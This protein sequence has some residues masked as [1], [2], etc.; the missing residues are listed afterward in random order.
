MLHQTSF[1]V[2]YKRGCSGA[3]A[4][5][6]VTSA[7]FKPAFATSSTP[8]QP[9]EVF[10]AERLC[11]AH[12]SQLKARSLLAA[13][14]DP[15]ELFVV[16]GVLDSRECASI[17]KVSRVNAEGF[18]GGKLIDAHTDYGICAWPSVPHPG[19]DLSCYNRV[20]DVLHCCFA[21]S[22]VVPVAV[23]ALLCTSCL[24]C[25]AHPHD[26]PFDLAAVRE[27]WAPCPG[28]G[29]CRTSSQPLRRRTRQ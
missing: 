11:I 17:I 3:A 27:Q 19:I 1:M 21:L 7:V 4:G 12:K 20:V 23:L 18:F 14:G 8:S 25:E 28:L 22:A 9:I 16:P 29:P 6:G 5:P 10:L 26:P 2:K 15:H 13:P 24:Q